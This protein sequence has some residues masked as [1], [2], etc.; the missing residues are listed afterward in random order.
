[1]QL[2]LYAPLWVALV[3]AVGLTQAGCGGGAPPAITRISVQDEAQAGQAVKA[4]VDVGRP[5][6]LSRVQ[7]SV[8]PNVGRFLND[9]EN[10]VT[11]IAPADVTDG[12]VVTLTVKVTDSRGHVATDSRQII[13]HPANG[14]T[15][16]LSGPLAVTSVTVSDGGQVTGPGQLVKVTAAVSRP[17]LV[18]DVQWTVDPADAGVLL[19]DN[20]LTASWIAPTQVSQDTV[21]TLKVLVT[22]TS[23]EAV[24]GSTRV[25]VQPPGSGTQPQAPLRIT[26]V[27]QTQG[28]P[29][30]APGDVIKVQATVS[31]GH[32]LASIQWSADGGTLAV[33]QGD[34]ATW[35]APTSLSQDTTYTLTV[36][37]TDV[38]GA[39]DRATFKILVRASG[40]TPVPPL[41]ISEMKLVQGQ[42]IV[43]PGAVVQVQATVT[44]GRALASMQW[45]AD[46]GTLAVAQ[47]S[48]AT[49]I[50]P[51]AVSQ[52]TTYTL[53][54]VATDVSGASDV[55]TFKIVVRSGGSTTPGTNL[56]PTGLAFQITGLSGVSAARPGDLVS[57][58]VTYNDNGTPV[59]EIK[60]TVE[61]DPQAL[62]G[63]LMVS[64]GPTAT[65]M[66][67][68]VQP[69]TSTAVY[70]FKVTLKNRLG[71]TAT[72][73]TQVAVRW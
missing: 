56:P 38:S 63:V 62:P 37:A 24:T 22:G 3:L 34:T 60:W 70:V 52:D 5:D 72:G 54:V 43:A 14:A 51:S 36:V 31:G 45:T 7:W 53:T 4:S 16:P 21:V 65:W 23:G 57:I 25:M 42:Q 19:V 61:S 55:G 27:S 73:E 35:I 66:A 10:P 32:T 17:D 28:N 26:S 67:P 29:V 33:S 15:P 13:L 1:M 69:P 20:E 49:W 50:A 18:K 6:L 12:M 8:Q 2:K 40:A 9:H 11:W 41:R 39:S 58:T 44:G 59:D 68:N 71:L 46:G 30:A 48:T 47:G 64:Q